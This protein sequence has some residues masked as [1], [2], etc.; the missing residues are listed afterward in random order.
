MSLS[1]GIGGTLPG[2][3]GVVGG[4]LPSGGT[5]GQALA[6]ATNA[7]YDVEWATISGGITALTGDVTASGT[8]SVA[9]TI[10]AGAVTLAKM[11]TIGADTVIGSIAGGTPAQLTCTSAGRAL[12]DDANASA[13]RTTLG[14]GTIATQASS[15][16][17]VTGGS[18][19]GVTIIASSGALGVVDGLGSF[20]LSFGYSSG[21]ATANRTVTWDTADGNRTVT[22]SGNLSVT[23][24]ASVAGT[25]TG[26]Q[27]TVSGSSGSCTG[28]AATA[29]ALASARTIN[30]T[31]FDGTAN[32]TLPAHGDP[33]PLE[34]VWM[35]PFGVGGSIGYIAATLTLNVEYLR[36]FT[37]G[38]PCTLKT[39]KWA[40]DASVGTPC[41]G[42]N[43][44]V[45]VYSCGS[46][47]WPATLLHTSA[48]TAL[49][50]SS[51][52]TSVTISL[53]ITGNVWIGVVLDSTVT[54]T[55][56]SSEAK[57]YTPGSTV[58]AGYLSSVSGATQRTPC[59]SYASGSYAS[60]DSDLTGETK[61]HLASA[62]A[63]CLY[64]EFSA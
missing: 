12:L 58:Y 56:G 4:G 21:T 63:F 18:L 7:S 27:T 54:Y 42:K 53:A 33:P 32:I 62:S 6:K 35:M 44:K 46:D 9:A 41:A 49:S 23:A 3:V 24:A 40:K 43:A 48:A 50:D 51:G 36:L 47:G 22:L 5:T 16:V 64:A 38:K 52:E 59:V 29:T 55:G 60:P 10:A 15:S 39:V 14:L 20:N 57:Y 11:A 25:N 1:G 34:G 8:G 13:Q 2:N 17:S 28:N 45:L 26:D 19:S 31:S 30:G 61:T 37:V